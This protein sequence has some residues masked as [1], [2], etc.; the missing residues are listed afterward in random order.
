[1][2]ITRDTLPYIVRNDESTAR[3]LE[4]MN[5]NRRGSVIV[6]DSENRLVGVL[7]DGD[8]RRWIVKTGVDPQSVAV[9]D[10]MNTNPRSLTLNASRAEIRS[11]VAAQKGI[12][13][14]LDIMN[15]VVSC[16]FEREE[17]FF[18]GS[19]RISADDPTFIIAEIGLN[20]NG[21]IAVGK[22]L[23]EAALAAGADCAK[24][25]L[26]DMDSLYRSSDTHTHGE[27]LGVEY[28]L[29]LIRESSLPASEVLELMEYA[30]SIGLTPL[31]TPWDQVSGQA[32]FDFG[33]PGFKVASADLTNEPLLRFLCEFGLPL[34]V[35]TGMSTEAEILQT[36]ALLQESAASYALLHCNSAYP[37]AYRDLNLNYLKKLAEIGQCPVGYS[38]H[39][40]GTT[41]PVAAVAMGA[42]IVEKHMTFDK[43]MRGNDHVV[44]LLPH[45]FEQMVK[46]IRN[47]EEALGTDGPRGLS[48]GEQLNRISLSKSLVATHDLEIGYAVRVTDITVKSPGRGIQPNRIRDLVGK[49]LRR[50]IEQGDFFYESDLMQQTDVSRDFS[51]TRP[52][53]LPVRFHDWEFLATKSNPDFLEFHLSY[54]DLGLDFADFIPNALDYSLIV[55]SP[56]LFHNDLILDLASQD[57][58]IRSA[59]S[60][61]LQRVVDLTSKMAKRFRG[62]EQPKVVVSLG[63]S[64]LDNPWPTE[65]RGQ[66]YERVISELEKLECKDVEILA[67]TLPPYPWYLGG[68]RFCNLFVVPAESVMFSKD[69]GIRLCFDVAHTKLACNYLKS[70]F[71]DATRML[72]PVSGHAH[73][74][75]AAGVDGEGL[76]IDEGDINWTALAENMHELAP[77]LS[78]I[79]E[80][81]QG[82]I[83]GGL[84]F[85]TGLS[86]LEAYFN[87]IAKK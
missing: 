36:V 42:K 62:D 74:V 41:I 38:G 87:E 71:E 51:F 2:I 27:D 24:F 22:R 52:W 63:G 35:S 72:L 8:F 1:V 68:Q 12:L 20:H 10:V 45:E 11:A 66:G 64:S 25:Q 73:L 69:A 5:A 84:G 57:A 4:K 30:R 54:R 50:P 6:S 77:S 31:C 76:Q 86:R 29:D 3:A 28:T 7:T 81:W 82:H 83:E 23:V 19:R 47:T 26:R 61:E 33:V 9:A 75:D 34:I 67:Q 80:I 55:H 59:S 79:P 43:S 21:D 17:E 46:D 53:G 32:L 37:A 13:P 85:W 40:R 58:D 15:H 60:H 39:E 48:Q 16:A 65:K 78:F 49:V 18:I 56:D 44:S 70:N 14:I